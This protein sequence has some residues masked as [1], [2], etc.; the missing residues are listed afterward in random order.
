MYLLGVCMVTTVSIAP[1]MWKMLF[2]CKC[3]VYLR[4]SVIYV[5]N[6]VNEGIFVSA[7]FGVNSFRTNVCKK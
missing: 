5:E 2:I 3:I 1:Y 4:Y 7:A 6:E